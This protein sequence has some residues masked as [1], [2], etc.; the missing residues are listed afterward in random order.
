MIGAGETRYKP[1]RRRGG[2]L[3]VIAVVLLLAGHFISARAEPPAQFVGGA[4]C[5]GC[6]R[7]EAALWRTSHHA[8]AMQPATPATVLGAF[9]GAE[10]AQNGIATS[11]SRSGD[12]YMVRTQGADGKSQDFKIAYTF[13]V[14]PLQQ[15]LIPFPGGRYQALGVAWDSR[16]RRPR[17]PAL[18][19]SLSGPKTV[20][21]RPGALDR[22]RSD[23]ELHVRRLPFDKPEEKL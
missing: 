16:P 22:A 11:F 17:R 1:D 7:A 14:Y 15:Y 13:G 5:S 3:A 19:R 18:V 2:A 9:D 23:L 12:D 4:A 20:A 8:K 10:L 21:G 6:H